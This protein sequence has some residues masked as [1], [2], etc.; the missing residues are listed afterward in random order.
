MSLLLLP[1]Q[2]AREA[3]IHSS[4]SLVWTLQRRREGGKGE[5]EQAWTI[6]LFLLVVENVLI[7]FNN[8]LMFRLVELGNLPINCLSIK[9]SK[10]PPLAEIKPIVHARKGG[11]GGGRLVDDRQRP[12]LPL[13][14][15]LSRGFV[16]HDARLPE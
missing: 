1:L 7:L 8:L 2:V 3:S 15:A 9:L 12:V 10:F 14:E 5:K 6:V 11:G 4:V 16:N 13:R